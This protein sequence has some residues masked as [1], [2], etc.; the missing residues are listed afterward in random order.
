V[1]A[2]GKFTLELG[3][4]QTLPSKLSIAMSESRK[5]KNMESKDLE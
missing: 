4:P 5:I 1:L 3:C 2:S